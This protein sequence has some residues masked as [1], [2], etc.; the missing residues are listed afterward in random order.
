METD[1]APPSADPS[2]LVSDRRVALAALA[3]QVECGVTDALLDEPIDR[4]AAVSSV[5]A[6]APEPARTRTAAATSAGPAVTGSADAAIG[7]ETDPVAVARAAAARSATLGEL[8]EAVAAFDL[9]DLSRGVRSTVFADGNPDARVLILG[10][11]PGREEDIAGRPFVGRAG[12][13]LDRMFAAIGLSRGA[14]AAESA[15]YITNVS[16]WRPPGNR[17][18]SP[19]EIAMLLPF[20]ERHIELAAPRII[21][22]MGNTP[23][24]ALTGQRGIM[25]ARGRWVEALGRPLLPMLHP[26]A[27]LRNPLAKREA[28]ADLLALRERLSV[29]QA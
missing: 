29:A 18:P 17:D 14:A 6:S 25:R 12:Q 4:R 11:A 3:W 24:F 28:W 27:L 8:R 10:E 13:L 20:V 21:V 16:F 22:S 23:L 19:G 1:A 9:C 26:A 2:P 5:S 7:R 15:L